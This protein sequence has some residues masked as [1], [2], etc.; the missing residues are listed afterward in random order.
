MGLC[1]RV[2]I[3][4]EV[5]RGP[6]GTASHFRIEA[7][8]DERA[9]A[10]R[11]EPH[12]VVWEISGPRATVLPQGDRNEGEVAGEVCGYAEVEASVNV[13]CDQDGAGWPRL[14]ERA[15]HG[16]IGDTLQHDQGF[17]PLARKLQITLC[18]AEQG[19]ERHARRLGERRKLAKGAQQVIQIAIVTTK[20]CALLSMRQIAGNYR[21]V[22]GEGKLEQRLILVPVGE[23]TPRGRV[24]NIDRNAASGARECIDR[25]LLI[26][27]K[28]LQGEGGSATAHDERSKQSEL[29]R[30]MLGIAA[31]FADD[32]KLGCSCSVEEHFRAYVAPVETRPYLGV[33]RLCSLRPL[34]RQR[35]DM[36]KLRKDM[37]GEV[38]PHCLPPS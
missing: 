2:H 19:E 20:Q 4:R 21:H 22:L 3:Y 38:D 18:F 16:K 11:R 6:V 32:D 17:D 26:R 24:G 28:I 12:I 29:D 1:R 5:A 15:C 37:E 25:S 9:I 10:G 7:S 8:Q 34:A 27:I 36:P 30:M 13:V 33:N 14:H 31:L 23:A 35:V